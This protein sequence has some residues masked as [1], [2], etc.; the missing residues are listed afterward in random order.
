MT[1]FKPGQIIKVKRSSW[2]QLTF[3]G[4]LYSMIPGQSP[5]LNRIERINQTK[6][7]QSLLR[8]VKV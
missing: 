8:K 1:D 2:Q 7:M 6:F 4:T 5:K 3:V